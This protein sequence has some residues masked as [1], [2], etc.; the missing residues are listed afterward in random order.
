M[1]YVELRWS[2][3]VPSDSFVQPNLHKLDSPVSIET[4][5]QNNILSDSNIFL[6]EHGKYSFAIHTPNLHMVL[7]I[8]ISFL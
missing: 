1:N 4:S 3:S 5:T 7:Y 2:L 6:I 8:I